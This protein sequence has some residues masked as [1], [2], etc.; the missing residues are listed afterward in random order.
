[1]LPSCSN[2]QNPT[3]QATLYNYTADYSPRLGT[4]WHLE[5]EIRQQ[6]TA[7]FFQ[8]TGVSIEELLRST[9]KTQ[10]LQYERLIVSKDFISYAN[11][12]DIIKYSFCHNY[13]S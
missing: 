10:A 12:G 5:S 4:K 3:R 6:H 13:S 9:N 7:L 1:M 11:R 8:R 2:H